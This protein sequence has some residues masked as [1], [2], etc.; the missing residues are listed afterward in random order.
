MVD[1]FQ[2]AFHV[3]GP[4]A[5][6]GYAEEAGIP[7]DTGLIRNHYIGRTF[8]EPSQSIRHFGV[9]I[10]LNPIRE[11]LEGKRV[12]VVDDSIVR[13]TTC[14]K[15]IGMIRSAGAKEIHMRIGS[16]PTTHSCF[17]GIDTP[18]KSELIASSKSLDEIKN[19]LHCDTLAY[20]SRERMLDI[21]GEEKGDF[22]TACFDGKYPVERPGMDILQSE[23]FERFIATVKE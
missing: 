12:V 6:M 1:H 23:L 19:F 13:G 7:F 10:K 5:A 9:K 8:I 20:L 14:R 2:F 18:N 3:K 16:P 21:F 11:L 4:A 17:Y 15:I 22:C